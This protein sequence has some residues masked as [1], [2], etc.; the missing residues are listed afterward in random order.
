MTSAVEVL[1]SDG[2]GGVDDVLDPGEP[3]R[4]APLLADS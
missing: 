1:D 4:R 2:R 3:A